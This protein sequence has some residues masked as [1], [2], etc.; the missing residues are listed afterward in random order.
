M[1]RPRKPT[2][3]LTLAEIENQ[4]FT[5]AHLAAVALGEAWDHLGE[6]RKLSERLTKQLQADRP[7]PAPKAAPR[8]KAAP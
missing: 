6:I 2:A 7:P 3:P 4:L 1:T 5:H 8:R